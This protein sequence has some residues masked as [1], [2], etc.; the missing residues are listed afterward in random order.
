[1][2]E[3]SEVRMRFQSYGKISVFQCL[4]LF[5]SL[6]SDYKEPNVFQECRNKF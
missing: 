3:S 5:I 2:F 1:M 6:L 4:M